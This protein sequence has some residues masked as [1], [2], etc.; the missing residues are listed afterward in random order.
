M[1][2]STKSRCVV[3]VGIVLTILAALVLGACASF[4]EPKSPD[5]TLLFIPVETN[6]IYGQAVF[7][8]LRLTVKDEASGKIVKEIDVYANNNGKL[9]TGMRPGRY[10]VSNIVFIYKNTGN[11]WGDTSTDIAFELKPG[12]VTV[13]P[14][15]IFLGTKKESEDAATVYMHYNWNPIF[16][17]KKKAVLEELAKNESFALWKVE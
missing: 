1:T 5:D 2:V 3:P 14:Q 15:V 8:F 16:T 6:D 17:S 10:K 7:G 13:F 9:V 12:T 11:R 4:P